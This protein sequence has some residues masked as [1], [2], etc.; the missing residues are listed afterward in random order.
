MVTSERA[1][2]GKSLC[3]QRMKEELKMKFNQEFCDIVVPIHGP[4]VT[5]DTIVQPLV[6]F[7]DYDTNQPIIFH[8]DISPNVRYNGIIIYDMPFSLGSKTS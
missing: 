4:R 1:G 8:L 7:N 6:Q 5:F 2:M 3:I